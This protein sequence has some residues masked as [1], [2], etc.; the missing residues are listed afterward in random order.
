MDIIKL[1][2]LCIYYTL[3]VV[4]LFYVLYYVMG[5]A[6]AQCYGILKEPNEYRYLTSKQIETYDSGKTFSKNMNFDYLTQQLK[7]IIDK[8]CK[9]YKLK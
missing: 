6:A 8:T 3:E 5:K 1:I 2:F 7:T 4:I 9:K